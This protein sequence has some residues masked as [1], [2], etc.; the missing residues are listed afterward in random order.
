M[1]TKRV[2]RLKR[3]F[4][5]VRPNITPERLLLATEA[6]KKYAGE[7]NHLFKG[8]VLA[9]VLDNLS[10]TIHPDEL[11]VGVPT[12]KLRGANLFP[13]FTSVEWLLEELPEFPTRAMDQIDVTED[14]QKI[15]A[16]CLES[17]WKGRAIEDLLERELPPDVKE[18]FD[19]A[20]IDLG[21]TN[22]TSGET[23]PDYE[24]LLSKGLSGYIE[25]CKVRI[26]NEPTGSFESHAKIDF[27]R[28]CIIVC[29]AVIRFA[30]R[31]A[32]EA[33]RQA[34]QETDKKRKKE[35]LTIAAN[36]RKVPENP[37]ETFYEALQ[38]VWMIHLIF[39]IEGPTTACSFGRFDQLL[40]PYMEK[41]M[42]AGNFDEMESQEILECFFLKC[43]EVIE[44][45][46]KFY[47]KA[48]AGF[49]M[50]AIVMLG[51]LDSEGN[52]ATNKL[53]YMCLTAGADVQTAQPVLAMRISDK[54][55]D[56]LFRQA[57]EMIQAGMANPGFFNEYVNAEVIRSKGGTEEEARNWCI[58][59][60]TQPQY[61]GGGTDGT[62]D[63][64][65][66][67]FAKALELVL[68]NG[69]DPATGRKVGIETG[70]PSKFTCKENLIEASKKQIM[71]L[72]E[73]IAEGFKIM[74][75]QAMRRHPMIWSSLTMDGCIDSGKSV[76]EGGTKHNSAGLFS[77]GTA[78][79]ADSIV[80]I[81]QA[82][83]KD[84][85]LT[86]QELID[87]L[88]KD[89][90][91]EERIRQFL[92]NKPP[93]FGN[94]DPYVD[95]INKE[96]VSYA[97]E[98]VQ[99]WKEARGGHFDFTLMSQSMNVPH[100]EVV[101]ATPDGRHA[102]D[103][104]NDNSSPM[105]GRDI[106]GP[107]ATLKSV[108][109]LDPVNFWAGA[110]FNLRFDPNGV[111]GEKG[112]QTIESAIKTFFKEGG[113]HIQINVV[114]DETLRKAQ[115]T[116]EDYRGLVVRVAGYMAYFTELDRSVQDALINRTAHIGGC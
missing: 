111:K 58:V 68:H 23:V 100:G 115:E 99:K 6:Y 107:T 94:D 38:A 97:A 109:S 16:E 71:F 32:D 26:A 70:D 110:L 35:L 81:E 50:W 40:Y 2:E 90:E 80:A 10:I 104:L 18:L 30:N 37:A 52:D 113:L 87:T 77:T 42:E 46:D 27:W 91:G 63:A 66:V 86:M 60:C 62:P 43:G 45:R 88:D 17:F 51:G 78:N 12:Y 33:E 108:A 69:V 67:N 20:V 3:K 85:L 4:L 56:D 9:Y 102:G 22:T 15:I 98:E 93:K 34:R 116:P 92:I 84:K 28:A 7:P 65:Y 96:I 25:D 53:S 74:Q 73:K 101:G 11:I 79:L 1:M 89:F 13:E 95:S 44:V 14:D 83:F 57:A 39:H 106:N 31:Y 36:C 82:V 19:T 75:C 105:M 8:K 76:Q 55:P 49:P 61:G 24:K 64:G 48:F 29:E 21:L 72:Y 59:G 47:S 112:I 114:D 54:T 103:P 41:D 5:S